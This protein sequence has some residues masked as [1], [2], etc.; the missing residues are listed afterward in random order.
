MGN[1]PH[2]FKK[3]NEQTKKFLLNQAKAS[4]VQ[5]FGTSISQVVM[6]VQGSMMLRCRYFLTLIGL[7]DIRMAGN[8]IIAKF[9][10]ASNKTYNDDCNG[11]ETGC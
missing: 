4:S 10:G 9:I 1:L 7:M 2:L 5:S 3:W 8:L 11:L 6:M